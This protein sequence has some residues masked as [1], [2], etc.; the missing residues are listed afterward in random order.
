M[1]DAGTRFVVSEIDWARGE[2]GEDDYFRRTVRTEPVA[3]F[4]T[5]D[6]AEADRRRG[7]EQECER[8]NR[9]RQSQPEHGGFS[10]FTRSTR[11][12]GPDEG[13]LDISETVFFEV[14]EID[15]ERP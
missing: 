2:N 1:S 5:F 14:V 6:E 15:M 12:G 10:Y 13:S 9:E 8:L 7:E 4:A 11:A 3:L